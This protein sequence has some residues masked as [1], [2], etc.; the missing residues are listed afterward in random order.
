MR[1]TENKGS[2]SPRSAPGP[3][4]GGGEQVSRLL[5]TPQRS[6]RS[7]EGL[8]AP[9]TLESSFLHTLWL[10]RDSLSVLVPLSHIKRKSF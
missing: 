5:D 7:R 3:R 4:G 10:H 6:S 8:L 2:L 9:P 1:M